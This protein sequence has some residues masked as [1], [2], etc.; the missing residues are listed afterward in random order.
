MKRFTETNKWEDPWFR[1]L[2]PEM[3][4]LW[5]WLLDRCDGAGFI[6]PDLELASF[7]I[8]YE[9]PMD[10]LTGFG[11]RVVKTDGEK[12]FIPKFIPFQYGKLSPDCKAHRPVFLSL[13][14][15]GGIGYPKGIHT[16][17]EEEEVPAKEKETEKTLGASEP[18]TEPPPVP[19]VVPTGR[20]YPGHGEL[21]AK[22]NGLRPEWA[23]P[24][25]WSA[26]EMHALHGSLAQFEEMTPADWDLLR[27]Y[28]AKQLEKAAGY[29]QPANRG[30]FVETFPDVFSSAQR[31][32]SKSRPKSE[33]V[34]PLKQAPPPPTGSEILAP[35]EVRRFFQTLNQKPEHA[36][37]NP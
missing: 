37:A 31:W 35:E 9:Y 6:E 22:I 3:K 29:W 21:C 16:H 17:K 36:A 32:A 14:K 4:L 15:N 2:K 34:K 1:R 26:A 23:K 20:R 33:Y 13:E 5:Q 18:K 25:H 12:Y 30:R 10:T 28:L 11:E 7:Q 24:S 19:E 8:G 27:R